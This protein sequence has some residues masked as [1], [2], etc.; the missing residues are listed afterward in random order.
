MPDTSRRQMLAATAT[1]TTLSLAG[2]SALDGGETPDTDGADRGVTIAV[3]SEERIAERESEIQQQ[4]EDEELSQEEAQAE[5]QAAQLEALETA[6]EAV[7]SHV[8]DIDGLTVSGTST[9][10][11]AVLVDGDPAAMIETLEN[12]DVSALVSA[13]QFEQLDDPDGE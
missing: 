4:L 7:E 2:C 6:V 13:A 9:Q 11:G 1:G 5:F 12:D 10:A 8:A 3:D